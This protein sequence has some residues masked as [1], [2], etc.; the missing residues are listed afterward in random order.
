QLLTNSRENRFGE[1]NGGRIGRREPDRVHERLRVAGVVVHRAPSDLAE[2]R[3]GIRSE[4]LRT[5]V[6]RMDGLAIPG[7]AGVPAGEGGVHGLESRDDRR[8]VVVRERGVRHAGYSL[9]CSIS[10]TVSSR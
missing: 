10:A 9:S 3:N 8:E 4:K 7:L 6:H 5:T 1:S 2:L